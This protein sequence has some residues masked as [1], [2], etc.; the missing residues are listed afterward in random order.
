M[1]LMTIMRPNIIDVEA[2]GFG[3][4]S[5]PIEIGFVMGSGKRYSTLIRP[6]EGWNH[7]DETAEKIH[8]IPRELL[9]KRGKPI[10]DVA[11]QLNKML[12]ENTVYSDGWVVDKPWVSKLFYTARIPQRFFL[13]PLELILSESQMEVWHTVKQR[14]TRQIK[15]KRHRA[16]ID[17]FIIQETYFQSRNRKT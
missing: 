5:Y 13:S 12:R 15:K 2:S 7:W 6:H 16:S 4:E 3:T 1:I 11:T 14:V 8:R 9:I 17:A 10:K